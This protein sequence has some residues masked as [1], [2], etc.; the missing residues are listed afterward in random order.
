[1]EL[2]KTKINVIIIGSKSKKS[3]LKKQETFLTEESLVK[4]STEENAVDAMKKLYEKYTSQNDSAE[5]F[6]LEKGIGDNVKS[7]IEIISQLKTLLPF[8]HS[9]PSVSSSNANT[10]NVESK[11]VKKTVTSKKKY[12]TK[13]M[14]VAI[15]I[16]G[17]KESY[18]DFNF[19]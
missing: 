15:P 17:T 5:A 1:M 2:P 7:Q 19:K 8:L 12:Y 13:A 11:K 14:S 16:T 18:K 4:Q 9:K 6:I 10:D 3:D